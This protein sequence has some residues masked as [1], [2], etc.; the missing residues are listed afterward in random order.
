MMQPFASPFVSRSPLSLVACLLCLVACGA[1]QLAAGRGAATHQKASAGVPPGG[2]LSSSKPERRAEL[3]ESIS[4]S[5]GAVLG[6]RHDLDKVKA[7]LMPMW[8]ASVKNKYGRVDHR[9]L[10]YLVHRY[11]L[12]SNRISIVGLEPSVA[13]NQSE[14]AVFLKTHAPS[15]VKE[16]L[17]GTAAAEGF[18]LDDVVAM[19]C[20]MQ[21]FVKLSAEDHL[22][23][24]FQLFRVDEDGP[25]LEDQFGEIM[26]ARFWELILS[27]DHENIEAVRRDRTVVRDFFDDWQGL[28]FYVN[29]SIELFRSGPSA[30]FGEGLSRRNPF[31]STYTFNDALEVAGDISLSIGPF[32]TTECARMKDLLAAMD[33]SSTGRVRLADFHHAAMKGEWRFSESKEYLQHLGALDETST[34]LGPRVIIANYVQGPN[35]CIAS[36]SHFRV[37]CRNECEDH[38]G[39]IEAAVKA[40]AAVPE[41][42]LAAVAKM[43]TDDDERLV[44]PWR[45]RS[46]L[47]DIAKLHNGVVP[48]HGRLFAQWLH[49]IFPLD[50]PYP[51]KA[52]SMGSMSFFEYGYAGIATTREIQKHAASAGSLEAEAA[53]EGADVAPAE[54][55]LAQ[56]SHEEELISTD[57]YRAPWDTT[58]V[59]SGSFGLLLL[60]GVLCSALVAQPHVISNHLTKACASSLRCPSTDAH[61]HII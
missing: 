40:P 53:S 41:L 57:A 9:S 50:C 49:Y 32:W 19:V 38:L 47:S 4:A 3:H 28:F 15:L 46:Q 22:H 31:S 55:W 5:I 21:H 18:S 29:G 54:D 23:E 26:Q 27:G 13:K 25:V 30:R 43:T 17:E 60:G 35:N 2:F 52:G 24:L 1:E 44:I 37:C 16:T 39:E 45:M 34:S 14:D 48:L 11:L 8:Q 51:H 42:I 10:R 6:A 20:M 59:V 12:K 36:T 33:T 61:A 58:P 7:S 56:W